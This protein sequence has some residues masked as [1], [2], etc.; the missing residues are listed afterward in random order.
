MHF[1][2]TNPMIQ[3]F[4]SHRDTPRDELAF[5]TLVV[6]LPSKFRGGC[7]TVKH[8]GRENTCDW[9]ARL[10]K[11]DDDMYFSVFTTMT[12]PAPPVLQW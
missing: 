9:G 3:H 6:A 2:P 12:E 11:E 10:T 7:L 1:P 4:K 5:G 8:R